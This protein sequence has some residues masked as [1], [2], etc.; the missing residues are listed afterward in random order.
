[1]ISSFFRMS[2]PFSI[3]FAADLRREFGEQ[4]P[5]SAGLSLRGTVRDFPISTRGH[6]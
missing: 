4:L 1:M 3:G 6:Q 2:N 5:A